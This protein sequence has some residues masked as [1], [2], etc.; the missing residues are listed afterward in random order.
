MLLFREYDKERNHRTLPQGEKLFHAALSAVLRGEKRFHV[1]NPAGSDY[2]LEYVENQ[3]WAEASK[4]Y[5]DSPLFHEDPLFPPYLLYDEKDKERLCFDILEGFTKVWFEEANEYTVVLNG[6]LLKFTDLPI[7]WKDARIRWFFPEEER[8]TVTEEIPSVEEKTTLRVINRFH[9]SSFI[10]D[11]F[12]M[13]PVALF[14]HVFVLQWLTDLPMDQVKYA[15]ILVAKSE[16]IGSILT[17]H[18]RAVEFLKRYGIQ[19]TLC[20]GSARYAD[21]IMERYFNVQMTPEDA[22]ETNTIYITNYYGLLFTKMLRYS[23]G[24]DFDVNSL[25]PLFLEEMREYAKAVFQDKRML[26]ILLRGS[27]YI[28]SGMSGASAPVTVESALPKIREWMEEGDYDGIFL[29]TE[30]RDILDKMLAAFPGKIRV[31]SQERY[32]I[33]DFQK[34]QVTT[35]SELDRKR[36]PGEE[37]YDQFLEDS[38]AN[39]FYALYLL[40]RCE[41]FMYSGQ[42]GGSTMTKSLSEKGFRRMWCFAQNKEV[43]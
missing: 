37:E 7:Q 10:C 22:D 24:H 36:H 19:I 25:N 30:D 33:T 15:E 16:G 34:E 4:E 42:C 13:D 1:K 20:P 27:D 23:S 26:G 14:H 38:T 28:A 32:G 12:T 5:P 40:S 39:Y 31:V 6:V 43:E 29:A 11:F 35:I 41:S 18:A 8:I 9:P 3:A 2:D 17:I 21:H